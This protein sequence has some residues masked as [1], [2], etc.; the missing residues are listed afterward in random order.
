M[1]H[2]NAIHGHVDRLIA[3]AKLNIVT[4]DKERHGKAVLFDSL[5]RN[6][7]IP[8]GSVS[9]VNLDVC[10]FVFEDIRQFA[11]IQI[12]FYATISAGSRHIRDILKLTSRVL[13]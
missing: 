11:N 13:H 10:T 5:H 1:P 12:L 9:L 2:A 6:A 4:A 7:A 3:Y 8:P